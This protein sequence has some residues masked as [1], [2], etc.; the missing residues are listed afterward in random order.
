MGAAAKK[1][2]E[3][4]VAEWMVS[5]VVSLRE[6][7]SL[8]AAAQQLETLNVSALPVLDQSSRL[9]GVFSSSDLL[10]A[11]RFVSQEGDRPRHLRLPD[12][13]VETF[14]RTRVPV[15]GPRARLGGCA[16]R[17]CKQDLHRLYVAEDGPLAGVV[18]TREML[19]A[20][21]QAGSEAP[22][23]QLAQRGIATISARDPLASAMS[24]LRLNPTLTLVVT[25]D[26]AAVGVFSRAEAVMAREADPTEAL[27]LWMDVSVVCLPADVPAHRGAQRLLEAK[28]RYVAACDGRA[29]IGLISGLGFTELIAAS[30]S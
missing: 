5:P 14:M 7:T 3:G 11:G 1:D 2:L 6:G 20:V 16:R 18:S 15:I 23:S 26:D 8:T 21:A 4:F 25:Q 17:M 9:I 29:I 22:L 27:A 30:A 12:A 19:S 10:R 13:G 28:R 24:R